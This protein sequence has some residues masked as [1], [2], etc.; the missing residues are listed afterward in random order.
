[1][2]YVRRLV[3]TV[4]CYPFVLSITTSENHQGPHKEI[5]PGHFYSFCDKAL[6]LN[7]CGQLIILAKYL[8]DLPSHSLLPSIEDL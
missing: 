3:Y 2:I 5:A 7:I 6:I 4:K 1:M 8:Q